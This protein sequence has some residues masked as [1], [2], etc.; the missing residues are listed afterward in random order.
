MNNKILVTGSAGFIGFHVSSRLCEEGY[1]VVG[2]DNM[3]NYYLTQLKKDRLKELSKYPNFTFYKIDISDENKLSDLFKKHDFNTIIHLAAQAGV[4]YSIENP[5]A[6][7]KS[8]ILGFTNILELSQ[9]FNIKHLVYASS[10]SVY[11]GNTKIPFS[12]DD[13]VD[14]PVSFYAATKKSNELMAHVYSSLYK[15]PTTGLRFF[16]V[17]GPWGRP[18]MAYYKFSELIM[19]DE[20]ISIYNHGKHKRSFTYIDDIVESIIRIVNDNIIKDSVIPYQILNIGGSESVELLDFISILEKHLGKKAK[21]EMLPK[22]LGDVDNTFSDT[23]KL[24]KLVNYVPKIELDEGIMN[25]VKW[26][27][28]YNEYKN[29]GK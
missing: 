26:F 29:Y 1:D 18:D 22:Q 2:I 6:Y 24:E 28:K 15:L 20:K 5:Q 13:N 11:G 3:N 17:Y 16:T 12:E 21:F 23:T 7:V 8:N 4:R 25:F 14:N 27:I 9:R 10:S 19:N